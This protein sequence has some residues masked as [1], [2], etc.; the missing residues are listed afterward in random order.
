MQQ[1]NAFK[2]LRLVHTALLIGMALF[3]IVGIVLVQQNISPKADESFQRTFQVVCILVSGAML[4]AGFN[5]F[6]K[7]MLAARNNAGPGEQRMDLYRAACILWW[8]MI[9]G[10]GLLATVGYILT[11]N[12]AFFALALFHLSCLFVFSPRKA[13]IIVLLNLTPAEIAKLE[14]KK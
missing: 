10:P 2:V 4:I 9:E 6:K 13:N 5:I 3:N 7:R 11:H 12:Y 8:A 1:P 14:G